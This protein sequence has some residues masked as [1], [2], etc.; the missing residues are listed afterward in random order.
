M[1]RSDGC[2]PG[3]GEQPRLDGSAQTKTDPRAKGRSRHRHNERRRDHVSA[4]P[5]GSPLALLLEQLVPTDAP[6]FNSPPG[7]VMAIRSIESADP[8]CETHAR[9]L[10]QPTCLPTVDRWWQ[11]PA[12]FWPRAGGRRPSRYLVTVTVRS[13][14]RAIATILGSFGWARA[15]TPGLAPQVG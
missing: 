9:A 12:V 13:D 10:R 4:S 8:D 5:C 6:S 14:L 11:I 7:L 3:R 1:R 15:G 2:P